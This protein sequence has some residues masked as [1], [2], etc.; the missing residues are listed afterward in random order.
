[1]TPSYTF[2]VDIFRK[3][4]ENTGKALPGI[5]LVYSIKANPFLIPYIP[6]DIAHIEVCS[7]G[8]LAICKELDV[9]PEKIIYSGV[10]KEAA[11]VGEAISYGAGILT[12][13]SLLHLKLIKEAAEKAEKTVKVFLRLS[14]GNQFGMSLEDLKTAL[15]EASCCSHIDVIGLHYYS[16][17]AKSLKAIE[18]DIATLNETI[19]NLREKSGFKCGVL[20]YGPGLAAES[21]APTDAECEQKDMELLASVSPLLNDLGSQVNLSLEMGRFFAAPCGIY[22]TTVKDLKTT[23][24]VNYAIVNGGTHHLKY[25]GP[26]TA[27]KTPLAEQDA[28]DTDKTKDYAICGALCTTAD[29]ITRNIS[30]KE[31]KIGDTLRFKRVGAYSVTEG[32]VLFLSRQMPAIYIRSTAAGTELI[33]KPFDSHRLNIP[34]IYLRF[35]P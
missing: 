25:Y 28:K 10:L 16:G 31:L 7:P 13:E 14:S 11:D 22:E 12:A 8:E 17:T 33:R 23:D 18:K 15:A 35:S 24:E 32:S 2:D 19:E 26:N 20:E 27:M 1:M 4:I 34:G 5:P 9:A 3:R 30:L 21:F 29:V 6:E